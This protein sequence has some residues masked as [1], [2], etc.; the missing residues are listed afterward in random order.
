MWKLLIFSSICILNSFAFKLGNIV[1]SVSPEAQPDARIECDGEKCEIE[2]V[3][4]YKFPYGE[5]K[6]NMTCIN[7]SRWIVKSYGNLPECSPTC[8]PACLNGGTCI[9]PDHCACRP[10]YTGH[11]CQT[12]LKV[13]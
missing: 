10:E 4:G 11:R 1:C 5:T 9:S 13:S 7:N 12:Q 8:S 6:L 2:C 3:E